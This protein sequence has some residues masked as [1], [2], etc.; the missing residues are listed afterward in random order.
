[1]RRALITLLAVA[2]TVTTGSIVDAAASGSGAAA[3]SAAAAVT[4][5][6]GGSTASSA[7]S[8]DGRSGGPLATAAKRRCH[9]S[10]RGRCLKPNA[11][12]YDCAGGS[13][14][15]PYYVRGPFRVVGSDPYRLDA[16]HDGIACE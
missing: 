12:D 2:G 8:S 9:P 3:G 13:G 5:A 6:A 10:Y 14:N 11:S 15:G 16:D 4:A 7:S 1:M